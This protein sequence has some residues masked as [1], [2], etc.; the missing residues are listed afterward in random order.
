MVSF[1]PLGPGL[2]GGLFFATPFDSEAR[3][4]FRASK[5]TKPSV[6]QTQCR[7]HARMYDLAVA[8]D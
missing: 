7:T 4:R 6:R 3:L 1:A 8:G 2:S 5:P